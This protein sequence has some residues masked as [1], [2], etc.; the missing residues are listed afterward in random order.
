VALEN[1][2]NG[3]DGLFAAI[4]AQD[5]LMANA[6]QV[7]RQDS[8][9]KRRMNS[10]VH[11]LEAAPWKRRYAALHPP[12]ELAETRAG[13]R[14]ERTTTLLCSRLLTTIFST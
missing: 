6:H 14:L 9:L 1:R 2:A 7:C 5:P 4:V 11:A 13:P 10:R 12:L 3:F 8:K